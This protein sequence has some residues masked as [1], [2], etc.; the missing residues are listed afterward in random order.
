LSI[1]EKKFFQIFSQILNFALLALWFP[2]NSVSF[3]QI[4]F[5]LTNF[6][7]GVFPQTQTGKSLGQVQP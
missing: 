4:G 7:F 6:A 2:V 1:A 3:A 5:L